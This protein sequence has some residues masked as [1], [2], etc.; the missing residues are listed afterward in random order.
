MHSGFICYVES[1]LQPLTHML[2]SQQLLCYQVQSKLH[3]FC[4][5]NG[6]QSHGCNVRY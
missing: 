4:P 3:T 1:N 2:I 5:I 6:V